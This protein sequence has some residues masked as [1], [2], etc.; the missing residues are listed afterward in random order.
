MPLPASLKNR[1]E[2]PV[3]GAPLFIVSGHRPV[4]GRN[5]RLLAPSPP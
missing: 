3:I 2:L 5:R 4:Q 1:L